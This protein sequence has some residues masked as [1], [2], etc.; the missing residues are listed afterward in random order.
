MSLFEPPRSTSSKRQDAHW[1]RAARDCGMMDNGGGDADMMDIGGVPPAPRLPQRLPRAARK[2][3]MLLQWDASCTSSEYS[4]EECEGR[5]AMHFWW[6][7]LTAEKESAR[8]SPRSGGF[9]SVLALDQFCSDSEDE[10][11]SNFSGEH[12]ISSPRCKDGGDFDSTGANFLACCI[13][14]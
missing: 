6:S 14:R 12:S 3:L 8:L 11:R 9:P 13:R 2:E 1:R 4:D 7:R 10:T 5:R